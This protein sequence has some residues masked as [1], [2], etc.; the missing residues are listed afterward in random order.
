MARLVD[1]DIESPY[2]AVPDILVF[3]LF[4]IVVSV[5]ISLS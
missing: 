3:N 2:K 5:F 4:Y 1:D